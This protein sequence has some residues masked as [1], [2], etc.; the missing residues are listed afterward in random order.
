MLVS[1][2]VEGRFSGDQVA[3]FVFK[4]LC[5]ALSLSAST[6]NQLIC[7]LICCIFNAEQKYI[8]SIYVWCFRK[9]VPRA[10]MAVTIAIH[11]SRVRWTQRTSGECSTTVGI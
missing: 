5:M 4:I 3:L 6:S 7:C 10:G 9:S 11:T 2:A 1:E 8:R